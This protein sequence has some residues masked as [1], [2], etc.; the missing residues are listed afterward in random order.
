[1]K[2]A[3]LILL[4]S[5][6]LSAFAQTATKPE[7]SKATTSV[8]VDRTELQ[9]ELTETKSLTARMQN[10]II[11]IRNAAGTVRDFEVRNA[12]QVNAD[13]WQD[14]LDS[15]KHRLDRLQTIID[16]CDAR[17]KIQSGKQNKSE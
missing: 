9:E 6:S 17:T 16:R 3:A 11:T 2:T 12:L 8:C 10:R 13:A 4:L 14:L 5:T 1:M 7:S 15:L